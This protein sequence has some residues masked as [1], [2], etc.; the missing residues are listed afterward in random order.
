MIREDA[1]RLLLPSTLEEVEH[2]ELLYSC[3]DNFNINPYQLVP[4]AWFWLGP[5]TYPRIKMEKNT[6]GLIGLGSGFG[7]QKM[8]IMPMDLVWVWC[9]H[10]LSKYNPMDEELSATVG[11]QIPPPD[12]GRN[13]DILAYFKRLGQG[14]TKMV[15]TAR[16][17]ARYQDQMYARARKLSAMID[18]AYLMTRT[19]LVDP[20]SGDIRNSAKTDPIIKKIDPIVWEGMWEYWQLV[21]D[22]W[23]PVVED[24]VRVA[25]RKRFRSK[26][27]AHY[28][29]DI[30]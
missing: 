18:H 21:R 6:S 13:L 24:R 16:N 9:S 10:W 23:E 7:H 20:L 17:A 4:L 1:I 25:M 3:L 28:L 26:P 12:S 2:E 11:M 5:Q 29:A 8:F 30:T 15:P 14:L 19:G 27:P 22:A